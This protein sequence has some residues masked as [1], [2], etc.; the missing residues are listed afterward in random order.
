MFKRALN[1]KK[2]IGTDKLLNFNAAHVIPARAFN[3]ATVFLIYRARVFNAAQ[4]DTG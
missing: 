3:A 4:T 1:A 2:K